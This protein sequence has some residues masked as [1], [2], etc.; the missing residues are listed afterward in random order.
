MSDHPETT[1]PLT[2]NQRRHLAHIR[3]AE[4]AGQTLKAYAAEHGLSL[5]ALYSHKAL[6]R[7][8][9]HLGDA[10]ASFARVQ[11]AHPSSPTVALR[12]RLGNGILVEAGESM[13]PQALLA[14]CQ[15]LHRLS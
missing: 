15:R 13:D 14:L 7:K 11:V 3:A 5:S 10:Q 9:G 6:L 8:R 4:Q 12:I 2:D 1:P